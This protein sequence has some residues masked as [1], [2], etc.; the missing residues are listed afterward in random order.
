MRESDMGQEQSMA[1][2][3]ATIDVG[4]EQD[5]SGALLSPGIALAGIGACEARALELF[6]GYTII[7]TRGGWRDGTGQDFRERGIRIEVYASGPTDHSM[8]KIR[9]FAHFITVEF[10]Q[11]CVALHVQPWEV[12]YVS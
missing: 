4:I 9:A 1:T 2:L 8:A 11:A 7:Q 5:Y 10:R 12:D 3:K 6:G